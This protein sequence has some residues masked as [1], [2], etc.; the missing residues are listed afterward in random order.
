M[1]I[2]IKIVKSYSERVPVHIEVP[3][4]RRLIVN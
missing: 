3:A 1:P 4:W 2:K